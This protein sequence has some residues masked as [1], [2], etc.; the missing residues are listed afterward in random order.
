M[1]GDQKDRLQDFQTLSAE[2][3]QQIADRDAA[4][5]QEVLNILKIIKTPSVKHIGLDGSRAVWLIALHNP[6]FKDIGP[7]VLRKMRALFYRNKEQVFYPGIPYLADRL[8]VGRRSFD[9]KA[10]QLYGTQR[11]VRRFDDG[12]SESGLFPIKDKKNLGLRRKK[13]GLVSPAPNQ[14]KS[15]VH[16]GTV[17]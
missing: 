14:A 3:L 5:A 6:D 12:T 10:K 13:F 9:H 2:K 4:R 8:M 11:W 15:C 16:A 17:I 1:N 7:L